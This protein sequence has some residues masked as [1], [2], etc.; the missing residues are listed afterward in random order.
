MPIHLQTSLTLHMA[1][2]NDTGH[3][4]GLP[5][6][7]PINYV[8]LGRDLGSDYHHLH[9]HVQQK[10]YSATSTSVTLLLNTYI[11]DRQPLQMCSFCRVMLFVLHRPVECPV[12]YPNL[13]H[14]M[15]PSYDC[16]LK[17]YT[18]SKRSG[19]TMLM[20]PHSL[21]KQWID[22]SHQKDIQIRSE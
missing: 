8:P 13:A 5:S 22:C 6:K 7:L 20:T 14:Q 16:R 18:R 4:P 1:I 11:L 17:L 9:G 19:C 21:V 10:P 3:R 2:F 15:H 12:W